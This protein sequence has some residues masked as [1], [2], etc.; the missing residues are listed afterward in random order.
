VIDFELR[1]PV[2][3]LERGEGAEVGKVTIMGLADGRQT[4]AALE[5]PD[6]DF[7]LVVQ[8]HDRGRSVRCYGTLNRA[9]RSFVI[10]EAREPA[11]ENE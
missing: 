4:R 10:H 5:F 8:A 7:Q 3:N 11:I 2:V 9:G 6:P 1:G